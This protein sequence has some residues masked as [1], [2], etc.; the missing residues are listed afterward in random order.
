MAIMKEGLRSKL[1]D[2]RKEVGKHVNQ[3]MKLKERVTSLIKDKDCLEKELINKKREPRRLNR[4]LEK[5]NRKYKDYVEKHRLNLTEL[6][7]QKSANKGLYESF[8]IA[9]KEKLNMKEDFDFLKLHAD[10]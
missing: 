8:K 3:E 9:M 1:Q 5:C 6:N 10:V 7:R 2:S 4:N